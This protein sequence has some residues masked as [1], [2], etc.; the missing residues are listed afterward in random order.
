MADTKNINQQLLTFS[1]ININTNQ[2][3]NGSAL[4]V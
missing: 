2:E 4:T 1:N 3:T